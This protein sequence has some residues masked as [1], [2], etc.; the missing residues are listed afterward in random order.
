[1]A[2]ELT[3]WNQRKGPAAEVA[4][5][6]AVGEE[7]ER[8]AGLF[9]EHPEQHVEHED[10]QHRDHLVPR[11]LAL[12]DALDQ[13]HHRRHHEQRHQNGLQGARVDGQQE[14]EQRNADR[15]AEHCHQTHATETFLSRIGQTDALELAAAGPEPHQADHHADAG[16]DEHPL[17]VRVGV[18]AEDLARQPAGDDRRDHRADVDAH[19]EDRE[20]GI[21]AGIALHVELADHGRDD[22]LEQAVA[23]D[24]RRQAQLEQRLARRG[25]HEQAQRHEHRAEQDR[26]LEADQAVGDV[27][28]EDRT[29]IDQREVRAVHLACRPFTGGI[30]TVELRDDVQDHRPADAVEREALPE[31]RHEEHPQRLGMPEDLGKFGWCGRLR[32]HG[33]DLGLDDVGTHGEPL[34]IRDWRDGPGP[35]VRRGSPTPAAAVNAA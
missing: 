21:A 22:R 33:R 13:Q 6:D 32:R 25:Q 27:A 1:M 17:V 14:V 35:E 3:D 24:D 30:A 31:L 4:V 12:A 19:V 34:G 23:D 18:G 15:G 20:T 9:E 26:T 16:G 10:D 2:I 28:A 7:G 11:D 29:G 8:A 5:D